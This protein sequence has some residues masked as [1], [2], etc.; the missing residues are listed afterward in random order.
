MTMLRGGTAARVFLL[1]AAPLSMLLLAGANVRADDRERIVLLEENDSLYFNSDRHYT[2]GL[3]FSYLGLDAAPE[4]SWN[5]PFDALAIGPVFAPGAGVS[6]RY[7]VSVGQSLFTP[8][9]ISR[10]P[11]DLRDRPYAGW[12]YAGVSLL[13][14]T[15]KNELENVELQLGVVGPGAVGEETQ[16]DYHQFIG[17]D[18]AKGWGSQIR[19]EPGVTLSY[20]RLW[21]VPVLAD[22]DFGIDVV[23]GA[24]AT[25]GNVLTYGQIGGLVRLGNRLKA[26]YGPVRIRPD[27]SG[28]DYYDASALGD[29]FGYYLFAGV[30]GRMVG[31]N[32]FLDGNSFRASASVDK[33][34][35]VGDALAGFSLFWSQSARV[36]FSVVERSVE[37][38]GQDGPDAIGAASFTYS[39]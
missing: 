4:S 12:L 2:Q 7:A 6:R 16:N 37:F 21:R 39:W 34:V 24:G 27:L 17:A 25:V 38:D 23:P 15:N 30:Q 35:L 8:Q 29:G 22:D 36:D 31:R 33:N 14:E 19:G 18:T 26:D 28:T 32:I 3:R 1:I 9:D 5:A 11:P 20:D 10:N 13:Q